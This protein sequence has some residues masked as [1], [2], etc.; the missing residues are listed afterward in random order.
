M[1][2]VGGQKK[3]KKYIKVCFS[4]TCIVGLIACLTWASFFLHR[5]TYLS[6]LTF[7]PCWDF[8]NK[9]LGQP[10]VMD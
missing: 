1:G 10:H 2:G 7:G 9:A 8:N 6:V 3:E 5:N 4:K